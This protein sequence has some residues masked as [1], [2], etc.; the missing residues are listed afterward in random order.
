MIDGSEKL[1]CQLAFELQISCVYEN[2]SNCA[3]YS[4][5]SLIFIF[6]ETLFIL[7]ILFLQIYLIIFYTTH[8]A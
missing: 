4:L 1:K 3:R 5:T 2:C 7:S 6:P 8:L